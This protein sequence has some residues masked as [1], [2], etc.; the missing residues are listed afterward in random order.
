MYTYTLPLQRQVRMILLL[1][2]LDTEVLDVLI[3]E[4]Q[5]E[6][7][8]DLPSGDRVAFE[9]RSFAHFHGTDLAA[10][11]RSW[12]QFLRR[13]E[14][15]PIL[16]I[17]AY[18]LVICLVCLG[19]VAPFYKRWHHRS[20]QETSRQLSV[21]RLQE[22]KTSKPRLLQ[23]IVRLDEQHADGRIAEST[24]QQPQVAKTPLLALEQQ[25]QREPAR[26]TRR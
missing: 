1:R 23:S 22:L 11:S 2:V 26:A 20:M 17:T 21:A 14:T 13:T 10:Q 24:Y 16:Q 12:V 25:L 4:T 5:L 18:G 8:S 3:E 19:I 7:T 9:S 15:A 6:A